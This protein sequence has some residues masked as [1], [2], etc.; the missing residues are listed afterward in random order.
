ML[1]SSRVGAEVVVKEKREKDTIGT[2]FKGAL[3]TEIRIAKEMGD[4][5]NDSKLKWD[6]EVPKYNVFNDTFYFK[7][8]SNRAE[9][10]PCG[11]HG[12]ALKYTKLPRLMEV[13]NNPGECGTLYGVSDQQNIDL[14]F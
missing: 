5:E 6:L 9:L 11:T 3:G 7:W 2:N 12:C 1:I 14:I 8:T 4:L 13:L 10:M